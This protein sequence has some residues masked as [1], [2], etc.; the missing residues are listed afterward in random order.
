MGLKLTYLFHRQIKHGV[1][2]IEDNFGR[3]VLV[4]EIEPTE[5]KPAFSIDQHLAS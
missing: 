1:S 4:A 3:H 2:A 5:P